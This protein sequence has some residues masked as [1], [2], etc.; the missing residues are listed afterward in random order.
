MANGFA[1]LSKASRILSFCLSFTLKSRPFNGAKK[2]TFCTA[3]ILYKYR[4]FWRP[5]LFRNARNA[6]LLNSFRE[7][8]SGCSTKLVNTG[9]YLP[10][11]SCTK[12]TQSI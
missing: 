9:K 12:S 8:L 2:E 6:N 11:K 5:D 3:S 1:L 4:S 10:H 7:K